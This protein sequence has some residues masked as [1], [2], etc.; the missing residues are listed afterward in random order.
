[1]RSGAWGEV[2]LAAAAA[3]A[4]ISAS[5][6]WRVAQHWRALLAGACG[7]LLHALVLVIMPA[8]PSAPTVVATAALASLFAGGVAM[9]TRHPLA[10]FVGFS[11]AAALPAWLAPSAVVRLPYVAVLNVAA[12]Y[13]AYRLRRPQVSVLAALVAAPMVTA[14]GGGLAAACGAVCAAAALVLVGR[15]PYVD[16]RSPRALAVLA[17]IGFALAGW[18]VVGVLAAPAWTKAVAL[19]AVGTL[20]AIHSGSA[21]LRDETFLTALKAGAVLLLLAAIGTGLGGTGLAPVALFLAL[22]FAILA[23]TLCDPYLRGI[24]ALMLGV[25][26]ACLTNAPPNGP[27]LLA[28]SV[29]AGCLYFARVRGP[30][31]PLLSAFLLAIAHLSLIVGFALLGGRAMVLGLYLSMALL[32]GVLGRFHRQVFG[33]IGAVLC[34]AA[35][36]AWMLLVLPADPM[37]MLATGAGIVPHAWLARRTTGARAPELYVVL[38]GIFAGGAALTVLPDAVGWALTS[39]AV[40]AGAGFA[41]VQ[42]YRPSRRT[43]SV[44]RAA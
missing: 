16:R 43:P 2:A 18:T 27:L 30:G 6:L 9:Q 8:A 37:L 10:L 4:G 41:F 34:V 36:A 39:I 11:L 5:L 14:A 12:A 17:V 38:A 20:A 13:G 24:G 33:E 25:G 42:C 1:V 19:F 44:G 28:A 35:A 23:L 29:V 21:P 15:A 26:V 22:L 7:L 40:L 3:L 31:A 32:W